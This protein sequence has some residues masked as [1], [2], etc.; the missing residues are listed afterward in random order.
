VSA[1]LSVFDFATPAFT[2]VL[3]RV[4][5]DVFDTATR[6]G[7]DLIFTNNSAWAIDGGR[8]RFAAFAESVRATVEPHR[9]TRTDGTASV[10]I[11][12][13]RADLAGPASPRSGTLRDG[14]RR[15]PIAWRWR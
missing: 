8:T 13:S 9:T 12:G 2:E 4:R 1:L 3:H 6:N 5:L 15:H 7:V 11:G 14:L 10:P